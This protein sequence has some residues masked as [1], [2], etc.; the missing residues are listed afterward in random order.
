MISWVCVVV[1]VMLR[2][3][4]LPY[5]TKGRLHEGAGEMAQWLR[6]HTVITEDPNLVPCAHVGWPRPLVAVVLGD[7]TRSLSSVACVHIHA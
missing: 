6:V 3:F 4:L 1:S 5:R 2:F 7:L